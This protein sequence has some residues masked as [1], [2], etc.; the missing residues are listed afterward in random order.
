[1]VN[2]SETNIGIF[3][4][5]TPQQRRQSFLDPFFLPTM[6]QVKSAFENDRDGA[7]WSFVFRYNDQQHN[8]L[9]NAEYIQT[10]ADYLS[11]RTHELRT[12]IQA[13]LV[14]LQA[15]TYSNRLAYFLKRS[16]NSQLITYVSVDL[17]ER[18]NAHDDLKKAL[19][20]HH[21]NI[22]ICPWMPYQKDWTESFRGAGVQEYIL[23]GEADG[24]CCGDEW[25]TWG[26][27]A[28]EHEGEESPYLR[29]GYE[30][31][32][33]SGEGWEHLCGTDASP[34]RPYHSQTISFRKIGQ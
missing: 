16:V 30:R 13:P 2:R 1:M 14:V 11:T 7:L 8:F 32:D 18:S 28:D 29:D 6:A 34:D 12:T 27:M 3:A 23:I 15:G 9:L 4:Y 22:V 33:L 24:G 19:E 20:H 17:T 10:F 5:L 26:L 21:P 31:F 25:L